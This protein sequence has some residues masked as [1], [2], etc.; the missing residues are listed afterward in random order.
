[1]AQVR[2]GVAPDVDRVS[3]LRWR[4]GLRGRLGGT[5]RRKVV[6]RRVE[7]RLILLHE[8]GSRGTIFFEKGFGRLMNR[9]IPPFADLRHFDRDEA[10]EN[11]SEPLMKVRVEC[12]PPRLARSDLGLEWVDLG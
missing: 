4:L 11:G 1:P 10:V 8:V 3:R 7:G 6:R 2:P 5:W 12:R 9:P